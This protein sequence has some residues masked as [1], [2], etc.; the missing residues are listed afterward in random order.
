M[1]P[2]LCLNRM[3]RRRSIYLE[4]EI[5]HQGSRNLEGLS[6]RTLLKLN[7]RVFYSENPRTVEAVLSSASLKCFGLNN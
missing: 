7:R 1:F 5:S 4:D 3:L 2:L 6:V